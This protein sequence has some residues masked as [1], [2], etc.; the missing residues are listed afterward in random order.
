M[1][2]LTT[3]AAPVADLLRERGDSI[4][5]AESS[6]GGLI[7]AALLSIGGA[8]AW[9][10]GGLVIYTL[11]SRRDWLDLSQADVAGLQPLTIEMSDHFAR[12]VRERR[13][14]TWGIAELGATGPTG[15]RYGHDPG[16]SAIAVNGPRSAGRVIETG[17]A[18]REENMWRF[19]A[20]A[21]QLLEETLRE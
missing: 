8:S 17:S 12:S 18:D 9:Y 5:V 20:E 2:D 14:C 4:A 1:R 16:I 6:T 3:L 19:L 21:M 13:G 7:S 15:T 10:R 11:E